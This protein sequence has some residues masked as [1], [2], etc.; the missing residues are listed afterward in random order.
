MTVVQLSALQYDGPAA[1][2]GLTV[3]ILP[4]QDVAT[5]ALF[6]VCALMTLIRKLMLLR[7]E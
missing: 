2:R 5:Q 4:V 7:I 3:T 6:L 1:V